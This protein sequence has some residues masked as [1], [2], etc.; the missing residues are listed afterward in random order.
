MRGGY[1][2]GR[3]RSSSATADRVVLEDES[4]RPSSRTATVEGDVPDR[5]D[6]MASSS[7]RRQTMAKMTRERAL[8]EKRAR[9]Q[10][11][12]EARKAAAAAPQEPPA[13]EEPTVE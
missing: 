3:R 1:D 6:P 4:A 5:K 11:K 7:K 2:D 13:E 8:I 9:K 10:E 12:I